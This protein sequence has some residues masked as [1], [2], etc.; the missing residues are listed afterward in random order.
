MKKQQ[1]KVGTEVIYWSVIS[2][3]RKFYPKLTKITSEPWA[4]G[5][6]HLVCKVEGIAGGV[7]IDHLE[8]ATL[9]A[10]DNAIACL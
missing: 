9:K 2:N 3:V 4:L 1:I 8:P 10:I 7:C 5:S 6:G